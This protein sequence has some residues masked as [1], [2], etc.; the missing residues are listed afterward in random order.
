MKCGTNASAHPALPLDQTPSESRSGRL[1][2]AM[3]A[4]A[5]NAAAKSCA[6]LVA[7]SSRRTVATTDLIISRWL[8]SPVEATSI[9][10]SESESLCPADLAEAR[11]ALRALFLTSRNRIE[12]RAVKIDPVGDGC[13]GIDDLGRAHYI[14][15]GRSNAEHALA[16]R[17]GSE[18]LI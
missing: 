13:T 6:I 16:H 14:C 2:R 15:A 17:A 12:P 3:I 10:C 5:L 8:V 7:L 18:D 1:P 4:R 11:P 9:L